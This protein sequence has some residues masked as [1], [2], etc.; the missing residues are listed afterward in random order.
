MLVLSRR[1]GERLVIDIGDDKIEVAV[2]E[3]KGNQVSLGIIAPKHIPVHREEVYRRLKQ[4]G[5]SR[6]QQS[7]EQ[8]ASTR[9]VEQKDA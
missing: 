7:S 9:K 4:G 2:T 6:Y 1:I 3:V 8:V 5:T